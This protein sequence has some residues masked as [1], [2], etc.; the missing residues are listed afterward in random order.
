MENI[1]DTTWVSG[2]ASLSRI[3]LTSAEEK[4]FAGQLGAVLSNFE[5]LN[6]VD[7]ENVEPTANVTGLSNITRE[8][9]VTNASGTK[10]RDELLAGAPEVENG[11]IKVPSVFEN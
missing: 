7:T 8:D 6:K 11:S 2:V 9:K 5:L 10:S 1:S 4:K 3:K